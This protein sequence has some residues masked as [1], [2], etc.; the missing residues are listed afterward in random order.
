M[1]VATLSGFSQSAM[2]LA[3]VRGFWGLGN[4]TLYEAVLGLG[5]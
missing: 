3:A 2:Q 5:I 4:V 1:V